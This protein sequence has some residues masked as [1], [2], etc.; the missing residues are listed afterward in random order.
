MNIAYIVSMN[1]PG[2]IAWIFREMEALEKLGVKISVFPTKYSVGPY[3]PKKNWFLAKWNFF[4]LFISQFWWIFRKPGPY[5]KALI[6]ALRFFAIAEFGLATFFALSM[7][8]QDV[9]R[10][11]CHLGDRKL[12]SG[13]F[14]KLLLGDIPLSVTI[15]AHEIYANPN[16]KM[17]PV[18]LSACDQI[19][20]IADLNKE[21]LKQ[22]WKIPDEKLHV[23]R[24]FGFNN[25]QERN[26]SVI[27]CVGRFESKKGHDVLLD[28]ISQLVI[29]G[30]DIELWLVGSPKPGSKGVD[31][32]GYAK[33]LGI[34]NSVIT[35]G[36]VGRK[37][38]KVL[39]RECDIFCLLS[40][41]DER[42]V[43]EGIPVVLMEAMSMGKPVIATRTGAT[44]EL[45]E[46]ILIEEE[47]AQAAKDAI[48]KLLTDAQLRKSL[49]RRNRE[50]VKTSYS[51][52]NALKLLKTLEDH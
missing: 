36:E 51:E 16:W 8:R 39:Y 3:M 45:V 10:I 18:A 49:G 29:E 15:H 37:V 21:I 31:I 6:A 13:Y 44:H 32:L 25:N 41:R 11:H 5:L 43:P 19:I 33:K 28:A 20:C 27:L 42:G 26:P 17:F 47:D 38:L 23:I 9:E 24:L 50:I 12:Y 30:F 46:E 2:L 22:K 7:K 4:D 40:R 1:Q 48:R 34:E 52:A 35:F 14:C